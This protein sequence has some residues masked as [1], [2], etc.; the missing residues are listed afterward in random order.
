M[1]SP[2]SGARWGF[3]SSPALLFLHATACGLRRTFTPSPIRVLSCCLRCALKPSA[4]AT[5]L[6]RS[7]TSTSGRASPLRPT[8]CSVYASP[9][10]FAAL[11]RLRLRRKTRYG[12]VASPFPTGTFTPLEAPSL[13]RRDNEKANRHGR[14]YLPRPVKRMLGRMSARPASN[15]FIQAAMSN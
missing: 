4:S 10:L 2:T 1:L 9:V 11:K 13:S 12:W 14:L 15:H 8:G 6:S 5:S 3:P 7:C